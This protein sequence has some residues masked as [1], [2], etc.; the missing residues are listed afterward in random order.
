MH[1][2]PR[3]LRALLRRQG[4][5]FRQSGLRADSLRC[6][7]LVHDSVAASDYLEHF[8]RFDPQLGRGTTPAAG[9]R[10]GCWKI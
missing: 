8:A 9:P 4:G 5:P 1:C 3:G 6:L 2:P 7:A 10:R